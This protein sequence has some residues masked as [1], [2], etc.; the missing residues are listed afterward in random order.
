MRTFLALLA[1]LC[2]WGQ[3]ISFHDG[4]HQASDV[5]S[6]FAP[7]DINAGTVIY[8]C[9]SGS[10]DSYNNAIA[11]VN[12]R[13]LRAFTVAGTTYHMDL[14][15]SSRV[16]LIATGTS[17]HFESPF[18]TGGSGNPTITADATTAPDGETVADAFVEGASNGQQDL[19]QSITKAASSL[20]YA[21][22]FLVENKSGTRQFLVEADDGTTTNGVSM[23]VNP[24]TGAVTSAVAAF[25]SGWSV[26][27]TSGTSG[28][29]VHA[30]GGSWYRVTIEVNSDS[31]TTIRSRCALWNGST[32]SY[33]GDTTSGVYVWAAGVE[34]AHF[35]SSVILTRNMI[36]RSEDITATWGK[37]RS[38]ATG[39]TTANPLTGDTTADT[40]T[41]DSTASNTHFVSAAS[42]TKAASSQSV[43]FSEHLKAGTRTWALVGIG[44]TSAL[45]NGVG[46]YFDLGGGATGSNFTA[47]S[48]WTLSSKHITSEGSGWY[49]CDIEVTT[50]TATTMVPVVRMATADTVSSYNGDGASTIILYGG[51][52][53]YGAQVNTYWATNNTAGNRSGEIFTSATVLGQTGNVTAFCIPNNW[54]QDQDGAT[55]YFAMRADDTNN[56]SLGRGGPSSISCHRNDAG[57]VEGTSATYSPTDRTL[58]ILAM[59]WNPG[60]IGL[61]A[62]GSQRSSDTSLTP[63]YNTNT[64]I[65]IGGVTGG[66]QNFFG[67]VDVWITA[68]P[69]SALYEQAIVNTASAP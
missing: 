30:E 66:G 50:S 33:A 58:S 29:V 20:A 60:A 42:V 55:S 14:V 68:A 21:V 56:S 39:D 7:V 4:P 47:G 5:I 36:L 40:L 45:A 18:W 11:Y 22:S 54:T 34:Q 16:N 13:R 9:A 23:R 38:T 24:A 12:G 1:C 26:D 46:A 57:G 3:D 17:E 61:F 63:P 35:P 2:S 48:G 6:Y 53:E 64:I 69:A 25:G 44:A 62:D 37:T 10:Y 28:Y 52:L 43:T 31:T 27:T 65:G 32:T 15:E 19:T 67:W 51:Q 41:E 59:N 8:T 49:K